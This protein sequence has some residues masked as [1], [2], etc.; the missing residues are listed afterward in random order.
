[1][2][3]FSYFIRGRRKKRAC[4]RIGV[5]AFQKPAVSCVT[6]SMQVNKC[7]FLHRM[8]PRTYV[9]HQAYFFFHNFLCWMDY[10]FTYKDTLIQFI[11]RF[12]SRHKFI[13]DSQA[14]IFI[15]SCFMHTKYLE[16]IKA[17]FNQSAFIMIDV[18]G[19]TSVTT[20]KKKTVFSLLGIQPL[21]LYFKSFFLRNLFLF[22]LFF[23]VSKS[24]FQYKK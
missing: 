14:T 16:N 13:E 5:A 21:V 6:I 23:Q 8:I 9:P 19:C 7:P 4:C 20:K 3:I 15:Y 11:N 24:S 1:M 2:P 10:W 17:V 22:K 12:F 18:C